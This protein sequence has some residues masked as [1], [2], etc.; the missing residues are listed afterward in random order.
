MAKTVF[1]KFISI[2]NLALFPLARLYCL[3]LKPNRVGVK[4]IIKHN[5][6][7]LLLKRSYGE[8]VWTLPGGAISKNESPEDAARREAK[9]EIGIN[10]EDI[11]Q[12]G[13]FRHEGK[14]IKDFVYVFAAEVQNKS[15]NSNSYEIEEAQWFDIEDL[16]IKTVEWQTPILRKCLE[17]ARL[18]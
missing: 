7:I 16:K 10:L 12:Y 9:E 3:I 14:N 4:I 1:K 6:E 5:N 18:L 2:L 13:S 15:F 17:A 11:L 8:K